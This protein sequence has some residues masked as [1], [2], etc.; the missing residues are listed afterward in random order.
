MNKRQYTT[1][2]R[3]MLYALALFALLSCFANTAAAAEESIPVTGVSLGSLAEADI[4][5]G[6]TKWVSAIIY[7]YEAAERSVIWSSSNESV[8]TVDSG[9]VT[10]IAE[11]KAVITVET[12]DGGHTD[13]FKVKV[14]EPPK[15]ITFGWTYARLC[16]GDTITLDVFQNLPDNASVV[17]ASDNSSIAAVE[18]GTVT[19]LSPGAASITASSPG[20]KYSAS[21]AI[22]VVTT[23]IESKY[24]T[25]DREKGILS[26]VAA[27]TYAGQVCANIDNA[28]NALTI[29][30]T[31]G[32]V[33]KGIAVATGMTVN[34][35]VYGKTHDTLKISVKGDCNGD[36]IVSEM[37]CKL[38][39]LHALGFSV[40]K[41]EYFTAGDV[42]GDGEI[43]AKDYSL[44]RLDTQSVKPIDDGI[45]DLP[46]V[47]NSHIKTFLEVAFA[48]R[49]KPYFWGVEGPD[50]FDCS[51]YI[52][53]C[54]R[55][56]GYGVGRTT[57]NNYSKR[58]NW[59]KISK[60][61]LEPGDLMFF[62]DEE[63]PRRMGHVG[64]YLGNGYMIHATPKYGGIVISA[65]E[66]S[67]AETLSHGRRVWR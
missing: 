39:M 23:E 3:A 25:I 38:V 19:A 15:G 66:G 27:S 57:A 52:Y 32:T 28:G 9:A 22:E 12:V 59:K 36:G 2:K 47:T 11:G 29:K 50:N 6:Q 41:D 34:L 64:I 53:Y 1:I 17:W 49:G 35:V 56:S 58:R 5:I 60:D 7:P 26:G 44:I 13:S 40:L 45:P 42:N 63:R 65:V 43:T 55:E 14:I 8:V 24:Y 67:Y 4:I 10:G 33:Y 30:N 61:K 37:D 62:R 20:T 48:Q 51:G 21:C 54:L 16:P 46:E 18:N 31:D